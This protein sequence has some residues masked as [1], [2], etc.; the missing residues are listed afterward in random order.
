MK[1]DDYETG[2]VAIGR[3]LKQLRERKGFTTPNAFAEEF[4]L[5]CRQYR[6]MEQGTVNLTFKSLMKVLKIHQLSLED[7]L[8]DDLQKAAA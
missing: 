8:C 6:N 3:K 5:P 4:D 2:L 1:I 7:F